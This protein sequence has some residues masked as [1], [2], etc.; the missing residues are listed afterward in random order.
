MYFTHHHTLVMV[1]L[2][3]WLWQSSPILNKMAAIDSCHLGFLTGSNPIVTVSYREERVADIGHSV[4][5]CVSE[6]VCVCV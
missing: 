1:R 4:C 6:C 5:L 2:M 3:C